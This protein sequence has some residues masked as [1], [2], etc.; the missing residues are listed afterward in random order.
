MELEDLKKQLMR[1]Y[2]DYRKFL[3]GATC[4][5]CEETD[6]HYRYD[7]LVRSQEVIDKKKEELA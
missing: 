3:V 7:K 5:F 4:E 6:S 1:K 2:I